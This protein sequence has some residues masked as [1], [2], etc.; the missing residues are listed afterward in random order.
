MMRET[1][2]ALRPCAC[3]L[4]WRSSKV[5]PGE[6]RTKPKALAYALP[7]CSGEFVTLYDAEDQ[8]H[9]DQLQEAWQRFRDADDRSPA[10]R[11]R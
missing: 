1:L 4:A 11:R 6:P 2:A 9:P 5:P 8:P 10:C 7:L 3:T